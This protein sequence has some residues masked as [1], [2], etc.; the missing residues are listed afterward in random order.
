MP[1]GDPQPLDQWYHERRHR[2]FQYNDLVYICAG[3]IGATIE[4]F[5][6]RVLEVWQEDIGG[7]GH[8]LVL[9]GSAMVTPVAMQER[10][11]TTWSLP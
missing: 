6:Y 1:A 4:G 9:Y 5:Q 2:Y 8:S 11:P 7:P 3:A 10:D